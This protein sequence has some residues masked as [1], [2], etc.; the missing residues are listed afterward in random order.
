MH[1][2]QLVH[3]YAARRAS[4]EELGSGENAHLEGALAVAAID[5]PE[6]EAASVGRERERRPRGEARV[7][8]RLHPHA[9]GKEKVD[10]ARRRLVEQLSAQ[11]GV[12]AQAFQRE[13]DLEATRVGEKLDDVQ[14]SAWG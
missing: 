13:L 1:C 14:S 10:T 11:L 8:R 3:R 4:A 6:T 2:R 7:D 12:E 5:A 9:I